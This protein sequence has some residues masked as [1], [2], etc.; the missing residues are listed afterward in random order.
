MLHMFEN[1]TVSSYLYSIAFQLLIFLVMFAVF[2]KV[3]SICSA[4]VL[5]LPPPP[6]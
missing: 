2:Y 3:N 6:V 5:L 1:F 4:H